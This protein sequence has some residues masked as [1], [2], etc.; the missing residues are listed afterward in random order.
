M[1]QLLRLRVLYTEVPKYT[2]S[3]ICLHL[4]SVCRTYP[5]GVLRTVDAPLRSGLDV[6]M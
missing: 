1:Q 4:H 3:L 6:I 5:Y 2:V